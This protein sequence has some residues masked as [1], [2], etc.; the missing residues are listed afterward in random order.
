M[1]APGCA[2]VD[3]RMRGSTSPRTP[4]AERGMADRLTGV[5]AV[6]T[7]ASRGI[8][9]AI[10]RAL[11][12][13]GARVAMLARNEAALGAESRALGERAISVA[14][15]VTSVTDVAAAAARITAE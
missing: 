14:C 2:A 7:G 13:A 1:G 8:G 10:V 4:I 6:V 5:T 3:G 15:D 12:G 9:L 11:H